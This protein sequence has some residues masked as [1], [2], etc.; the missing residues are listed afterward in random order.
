[1]WIASLSTQ[2]QQ[3]I[4]KLHKGGAAITGAPSGGIIFSDRAAARFATT[5]ILGKGVILCFIHIDYR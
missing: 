4:K 3:N 2:H 5:C 1:M